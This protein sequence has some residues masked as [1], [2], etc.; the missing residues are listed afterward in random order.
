M[1]DSELLS[2]VFGVGGLEVGGSGMGKMNNYVHSLSTPGMWRGLI[3]RREE[4]LCGN[5]CPLVEP[6]SLCERPVRA[7]DISE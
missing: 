3:H 6:G 4:G 2:P 5:T 7:Q 1:R